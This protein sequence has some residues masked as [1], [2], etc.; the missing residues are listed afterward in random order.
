MFMSEEQKR[1]NEVKSSNAPP[2]AAMPST[3]STVVGQ[4]KRDAN[5]AKCTNQ[6]AVSNKKQ[7][8][9]TDVFSIT[10]LKYAEAKAT[11]ADKVTL[12]REPENKYDANAV[13]VVN[14]YG[15]LIGRIEKSKAAVL[16][17]KMKKLEEEYHKQQ[18]KLL[19]EGTIQ[20]AGD[21]WQ[22]LVEVEFKKIPTKTIAANST[23]KPRAKSAVAA[24]IIPNPYAKS[25]STGANK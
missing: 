8:K 20:N 23:A 7:K 22:Q 4:A 11:T 14:G 12:L 25:V 21:G 10:G 3:N 15:Q 19:V 24:R 17:P 16:S 18:L 6:N 2:A 5:A 9:S 1:N 13:K